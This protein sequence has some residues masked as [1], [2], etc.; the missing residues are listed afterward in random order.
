MK[1]QP[2]DCG[3]RLR[4]LRQKQHLSQEALALKANITPAYVSQIERGIKNPTVQMIN[5]LCEAMDCSLT[6]FFCYVDTETELVS[7]ED[8]YFA[9]LLAFFR[10]KTENE[11]KN[12]LKMLMQLEDF[13]HRMIE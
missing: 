6:E 4:Q 9:Q 7:E 1:Q 11:K 3:S 2:F 8:A 10:E 13:H 5:T 12:Y